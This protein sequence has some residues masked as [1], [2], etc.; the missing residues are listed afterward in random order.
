MIIIIIIASLFYKEIRNSGND[1][2]NERRSQQFPIHGESVCVVCGKYR[3][4]IC[5]EVA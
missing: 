5:D 1:V 4:Y 3:E 2:V